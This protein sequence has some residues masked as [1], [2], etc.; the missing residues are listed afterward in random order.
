[1]VLVNSFTF[2]ANARLFKD[3]EM[4]FFNQTNNFEQTVLKSGCGS[5]RFYR[6]IGTYVLQDRKWL[7]FT[8]WFSLRIS[9]DLKT[10][11]FCF[12]YKTTRLS[13]QF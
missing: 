8:C 12:S 1:M 2:N 6:F 5:L 13:R 4:L 10:Q 11:K 9:E 3:S 7:L